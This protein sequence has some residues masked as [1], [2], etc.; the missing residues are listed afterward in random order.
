MTAIH[1]QGDH[2]HHAP[3]LPHFYVLDRRY[4]AFIRGDAEFPLTNLLPFK[5][6][7]GFLVVLLIFINV[8]VRKSDPTTANGMSLIFGLMGVAVVVIISLTGRREQKMRSEG[9]LL[10]GQIISVSQHKTTETE[11]ETRGEETITVNKTVTKVKFT[12]QFTTPEGTSLTGGVEKN[13]DEVPG[14]PNLPSE[15]T[16]AAIIYVDEH[17]H[18]ML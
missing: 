6:L 14:Y 12:Y 1:Q 3:P 13:S 15:G 9:K 11:R 10:Q 16:P 4:L 18:Q 2:P 5:L 7:V 8:S 17:L